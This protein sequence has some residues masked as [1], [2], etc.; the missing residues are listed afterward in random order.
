VR[1]L[2]TVELAGRKVLLRADFNV[3]IEN[4]KVTDDTRIVES[5]AT[6]KEVLAGGGTLIAMSHLGRPDGKVVEK[7][8]LAPVASHLSGLLKRPVAYRPTSGPVA[9]ESRELV[10]N[11]EPGGVLL[12]ENVR[13]DPREEKGDARMARELADLAGPNGLYVNDAFGSAHRAHVSTTTVAGLLEHAAGRLMEREVKALGKVLREADR[14]FV[15]ILG[16]AKVSDKVNV[17]RNLLDRVDRILIGGAMAYTFLL[18]QGHEVGRSLVER[19]RVDLAGELIAEAARRKIQLLLPEDVVAAPSLDDMGSPSTVPAGEIPAGLAGYDIG[20]VAR[21][22]FAAALKDARTIVWNGPMGVFEKPPFDAGTVAI[23]RAVA[24][25]GAYSVIG[26]GDSVAAVNRA[27]L[28]GKIAHVSTGG[29][30]SLEFLEG[31]VLPG[32]EALS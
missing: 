26:G 8:R 13:F 24:A 31:K 2:D 23:A 25:S 19:E 30:A 4:G 10:D 29:G 11:L 3:P 12:L 27:G 32:V 6:M 14:P 20:P 17:I 7:H 16:G 5:L 22:R 18:A 21:E 28:A 9:P 15:L 1:T